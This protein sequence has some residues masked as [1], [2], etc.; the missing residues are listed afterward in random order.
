MLRN[1][2]AYGLAL[3]AF[4]LLFAPVLAQAQTKPFKITGAGIGTDGVPLPGEAPRSHW[5]IGNA[6]Q[7]GKYYGL[8]SVQTDT[9]QFNADGSISGFF[10]SGSP[11]NFTAA[12]GD[13]LSCDYGKDGTGTF[14]LVP[15][16]P[17]DP[18]VPGAF[19]TVEFVAYWIADFVPNAGC[20]G[21]FAGV[22]GGWTMY[23]VSEPFYPF[24]IVDGQV[25]GATNPVA[26]SWQGQGTLTYPKGN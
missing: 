15:V 4:A 13:I 21:K 24:A 16:T 3:C 26:Y 6:T 17:Y 9:A 2:V 5:A 18:T 23:A 11:F 12:N 20:T 25:V 10:E 7:L 14:T 19:L 8:G 22:T 1:R